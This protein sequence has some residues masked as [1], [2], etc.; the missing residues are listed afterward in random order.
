MNAVGIGAILAIA[1]EKGGQV[2]KREV[3][4][5]VFKKLQDR[6]DVVA[7]LGVVNDDTW[8]GDGDKPWKYEDGVVKVG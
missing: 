3:A 2:L 4:T 8:L 7:I 1:A 5:E 6:P